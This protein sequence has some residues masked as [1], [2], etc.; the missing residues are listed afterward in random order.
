MIY[1]WTYQINC[2]Q[3]NNFLICALIL[4]GEERGDRERKGEGGRKRQR[5]RNIYVRE[6]HLGCLPYAPRLGIE[7]SNFWF[8]GRGSNQLSYIIQGK[9]NKFYYV[10]YS[11]LIHSTQN[12]HTPTMHMCTLQSVR[13]GSVLM[14]YISSLSNIII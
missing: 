2:K 10:F 14:T 11:S 13:C 7:P 3:N 9:T 6:N 12:T 5:E 1:F 4:E 8:M